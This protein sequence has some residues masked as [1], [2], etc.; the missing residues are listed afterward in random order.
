MGEAYICRRGGGSADV[1][2]SSYAVIVATIP[3]GSSC[4]CIKGD[5]RYSVENAPRLVA[6]AVPQ[7]GTWTV[8]ISDGSKSSSGTVNVIFIGEVKTIQLSYAEPPSTGESGTILSPQSGL[9]SGYSVSGNASMSG[10]AIRESGSGGF[11]LS[12]AVNLS[13]YSTLTVTGVA[14]VVSYGYSRICVGSSADKVF[15]ITQTPERFAEWTGMPN[16]QYTVSLNVADLTGSYYIGSASVDNN[17]E[18]TSIMLS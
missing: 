17:L 6:F 1:V 2:V 12:P 8:T 7:G 3:E 4:S 5:L 18:I 16:A 13:G 9:A 11:W 10:S 15:N 14:R